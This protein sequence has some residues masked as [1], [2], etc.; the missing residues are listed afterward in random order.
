MDSLQQV[1]NLLYMGPP[2]AN[3]KQLLTMRTQAEIIQSHVKSMSKKDQIKSKSAFK[4][5]HQQST[6]NIKIG[7]KCHHIEIT[8]YVS[9]IFL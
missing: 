3:H 1:G 6:I 2:S 9:S 4:R 7:T 8:S 5:N